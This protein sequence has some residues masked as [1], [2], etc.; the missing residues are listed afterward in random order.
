MLESR[1]SQ[2]HAQTIAT[3]DAI[4]EE[5]RV[6]FERLAALLNRRIEQ[7]ALISGAYDWDTV[8]AIAAR[9]L[10]TE[11]QPRDWEE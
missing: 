9:A 2:R 11:V 7:P 8:Q 3:L 10:E 4:R 5:Q 6:A 1:Q